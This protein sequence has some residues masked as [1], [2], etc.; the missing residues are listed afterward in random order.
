M[1]KLIKHTFGG[2]TESFLFPQEILVFFTGTG[3]PRSWASNP[4]SITVHGGLVCKYRTK[5]KLLLSA[6][7][8]I[9]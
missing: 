8:S 7:L 6:L 4:F 2:R 3:G 5:E 1:E 9:Y